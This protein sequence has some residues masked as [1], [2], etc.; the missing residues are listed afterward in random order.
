MDLACSNHVDICF[1][2]CTG[3]QHSLQKQTLP[4]SSKEIWKLD[5]LYQRGKL[6]NSNMGQFSK[7]SRS[8]TSIERCVDVL[9]WSILISIL[10]QVVKKA[11][12]FSLNMTWA[13]VAA[14]QSSIE[15][16]RWTIPSSMLLLQTSKFIASNWVN[17]WCVCQKMQVLCSW[18]EPAKSTEKILSLSTILCFFCY[19]ILVILYCQ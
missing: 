9:T 17:Y 8:G 5:T 4:C 15:V 19:S 10:L 18:W 14:N 3:K 13:K 11:P 7:C 1:T 16:E 6:Y 2:H 12:E